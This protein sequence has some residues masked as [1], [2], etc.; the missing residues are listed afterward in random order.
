LEILRGYWN[1][2]PSVGYL[3]G[4]N[5]FPGANAKQ[6]LDAVKSVVSYARKVKEA[7]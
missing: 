7:N 3:N 4:G 5:G 6:D 2:T 1:I